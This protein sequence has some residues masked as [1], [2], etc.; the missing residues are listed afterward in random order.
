MVVFGALMLAMLIAALDQTIVSTALPTIVGDL[1]GLTQ[2]SWVVTAYILTSTISTPLYGKIGDLYGR[3]RIFQGAI[4]I[5]LV[6]SMLCG[7]SQ[8]MAELIGFRALQGI[9]AGGLF[10]GSQAI[11]GDIV[12]PR[13]RGRYMGYFGAVFGLA[14]VAGPLLGGFLVD[15]ATWRWVFYI[16]VPIGIAALIAT[17]LVL[18]L[19]RQRREHRID[20]LGASLLGAGITCIGEAPSIRGRPPRPSGWAWGLWCCWGR[21]SRSSGGRPSPS[22][23]SSCS[24]TPSSR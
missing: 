19:P 7:L 20:Y 1:G 8:N 16:N 4:V 2:L 23:R 24:A 14:T 22:C 13:E 10:V 6:G 21:S 15:H 17:G 12:S 18:H 11:I 9:G 5:F 3:K